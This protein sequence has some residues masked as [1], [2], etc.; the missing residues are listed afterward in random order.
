MIFTGLGNPGD[1][2]TGTR[3]NVGRDLLVHIQGA[4]PESFSPWK[5]KADLRSMY[6]TARNHIT[7]LLPQT[8]MNHSGDAVRRFAHYFGSSPEDLVV[9]HDDL[10]LPIGGMKVSFERGSAGHNGIESIARE[11]GTNA[12]IRI[13]IGISPRDEEGNVRRPQGEWVA[14]RFVLGKF[15]EEEQEIVFG[16]TFLLR[17]EELVWRLA[18]SKLEDVMTEFNAK[19][20]GQTESDV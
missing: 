17:F 19:E 1:K 5:E 3:H 11:L 8:F 6:A 16:K 7:F 20:N 2:Y 4:H 12:F 15:T 13:R 10:D 14:S 9:V 18:Q